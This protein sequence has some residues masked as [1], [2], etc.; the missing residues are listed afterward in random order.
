MAV[1]RT[2]LINTSR[3]LREIWVERVTSR[4][5]IA[6]ELELDKSTVSTIVNELME[7]GVILETN[8]GQASPQGGRRPVHITLNQSFGCVVG[9]E[10]RPES[11][12]AVAVDLT[13]EIVFSK[14]ERLE[15]AG[16]R[17][18]VQVAKILERI[19]S[20]LSNSGLA[21][22]GVGAGLSGVVN[23]R[24]GVVKYS[25]PLRIP[26]SYNFYADTRERLGVPFYIENDANACAWGEIAFHRRR[27]LND[28][29]FVLVELRDVDE[30]SPSYPEKTAVG[31]GI[32]IDGT[33]HYGYRYSSGEFR[34]ILR[35]PENAG[36]F[37]LSAEEAFRIAED[38]TVMSKF[39]RELS[40][41]VALFVNTFDLSHVFLGGS[42]NWDPYEVRDTLRSAIRENWPY[43][44]DVPCSIGF[45]SL[46]ERAVA[47]GAAGMVLDRL[48]ADLEVMEGVADIRNAGGSLLPGWPIL[49]KEQGFSVEK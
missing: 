23:P 32:V 8:E 20:E 39:I 34:S 6:R 36:Q 37:S 22:L 28:F 40:Q 38:R 3:V 18:G 13:G 43:P 15:I 2:K 48:F 42:I 1:K 17:L 27:D 45:S 10:L 9:L 19:R 26:E 25:I 29:L 31:F 46:G 12:T 16:S 7:L 14:Y 35:S 44:D 47:Y 33:V 21:V 5:E 11:Y 41:H 4:V 49:D 30:P 24:D